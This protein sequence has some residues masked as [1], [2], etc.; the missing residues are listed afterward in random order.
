VHVQSLVSVVKMATVL[1]VVLPKISVL[2]CVFLREK[3]HNAKNIYKDMFPVYSRK[4]FS[5]K[6]FHIWIQKYSQERLKV[7]DNETEVQKWLKQKSKD[8][9]AV[10][11][12]PLVKRWD[13]V[14]VLVEDMSRNKCFSQVRISHFYF[15]IN[16]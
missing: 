10:E 4:C 15:S 11:F 1:E 6:A 14:S 7:S 9:Y 3:G 5:H 12:D 8:F 13:S 16:L 2:L